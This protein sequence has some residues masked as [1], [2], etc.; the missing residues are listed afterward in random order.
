MGLSPRVRGNQFCAA[1]A[2]H[3]RGSIP[4]RAGEPHCGCTGTDILTVYPRAC[5]GTRDISP[6]HRDVWGL[7]PRVRGNPPA[8][9]HQRTPTRSIPARAGEP[10]QPKPA[11]FAKKVYPRACGGTTHLAVIHLVEQGLSPRVRGNRPEGSLARV[12]L[13]SIPARA[14]EPWVTMV[15]GNS[16]AVYPRACGGTNG[17]PGRGHRAGG[18]SPRVRGNQ[19]PPA[20]APSSERSIPARA[21]EPSRATGSRMLSRVYPRACGGTGW[22]PT[23]YRLP[24]GLSP[25]VRGNHRAMTWEPY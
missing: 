1:A 15:G 5:G 14:G 13:R 25:R 8:V 19:G 12:R 7:S 6:V 9:P 23:R 18:L 20:I 17:G 2:L 22:I 21:G 10:M 11:V 24:R 3:R 4:A 16:T